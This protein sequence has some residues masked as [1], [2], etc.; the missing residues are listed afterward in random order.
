MIFFTVPSGSSIFQFP[1]VTSRSFPGLV[2][3][4]WAYT[5]RT[6]LR[7]GRTF[8]R[9]WDSGASRGLTVRSG[10]FLS[11]GRILQWTSPVRAP[12]W[13]TSPRGARTPRHRWRRHSGIH[14]T[15]R[16][17]AGRGW[18]LPRNH[19]RGSKCRSA[20]GRQ[21]SPKLRN[22]PV[23]CGRPCRW[24]QEQERW[25]ECWLVLRELGLN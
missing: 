23:S 25:S 13:G 12:W 7:T 11:T 4:R 6:W 8:R 17:R 14:R 24:S 21:P 3:I 2:S 9:G 20:G 22:R 10:T 19:R 1:P 16:K 18:I 15:G 5:A